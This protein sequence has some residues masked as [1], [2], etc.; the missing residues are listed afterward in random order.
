MRLAHGHGFDLVVR[1]VDHRGFE[2][3]VEAADLGAHLHAHLGVEI[4]ERFV[5]EEDRGLADD[6]PTDRH[7][8]ALA[9][10]QGLGLALQESLRCRG[11]RPPRPRC[12]RSRPSGYLRSFRPKAML[13]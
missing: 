13:S 9:A 6:G 12:S 2:L 10:G 11:S 7:A 8:L 1:D 3:V 5:E 4:G